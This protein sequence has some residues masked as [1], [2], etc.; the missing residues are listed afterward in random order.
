MVSKISSEQLLTSLLRQRVQKDENNGEKINI[1]YFD[2]FFFQK[3]SLKEIKKLFETLN[4]ALPDEAHLK[5]LGEKMVLEYRV[6]VRITQDPLDVLTKDNDKTWLTLEKEKE[7]DWDL[8]NRYELYLGH[9][10]RGEAVVDRTMESTK[11]IMGL[12]G[13]PSQDKDFFV[14]GMVVG[15]VQAGKTENFNGV[16]NRA[17]DTGYKII[18]VV[19]GLM[20]DLRLQ[21]QNRLEEDVIGFGDISLNSRT[22]SKQVG[23]KGVGN[24]ESLTGNQQILSLTDTE[25]DFKGLRH[26]GINLT[27]PNTP[28]IILVCKKNVSILKNILI[29]L[30][31][32]VDMGDKLSSPILILDDEADNASLNNEGHKGREYASKINGHIRAIL[33]FFRKKSYLGYTATPFANVLQDRNEE[34]ET[35]WTIDYKVRGEAKKIEFDQVDNLFPEDFISLIQTPTNYV[36]AKQIFETIVPPRNIRNEKLP[37]LNIVHDNISQFPQRLYLDEGVQNI[38]SQAE[39]DQK[40][41]EGFGYKHWLTFRD[42]KNDTQAAKKHDN[43]PKELPKSLKD[44]VL[45][46]I[47]AIAVRDGRKNRMQHSANYQPHNT[48]LVHVSLFTNW[49][50]VTA[51]FIR[52]YLEEINRRIGN[53]NPNSLDS[54]YKELEV[55]WEH[56]FSSTVENIREYLPEDYVDDYMVPVTFPEIKPFIPEAANNIDTLAI[57]SVTKEKLEY[58]KAKPQKIIAI[59]GNRLS[60]GFTIEGLTVNYFV[61]K[62]NFS[63][64]LLQMARWFGYR[65]GYLDCC[66]LFTTQDSEDKFDLTTLCFEELELAIKTMG[67]TPGKTPR[68][69]Q[70]VVKN[71]PNVLK[72]TRPSIMRNTRLAPGSF[73]D[74]L[75]M[76]T[77]FNIKKQKMEKVFESFKNNISPIF[78]DASECEGFLKCVVKGSEIVSLL[79]L[80]NNFDPDDLAHFIAYIERSQKDGK[81][82]NWTVAIKKTGNASTE[83]AK[84]ILYKNEAKLPIDI[85]LAKRK[86]PNMHGANNLELRKSFMKDFIF[87]ATGKSANIMSSGSDMGVAL[88]KETKADAEREFRNKKG[89]KITIPEHIYREKIEET[90]GV[91]IIYFFDSYYSFNQEKGIE[92]PDFD[93]FVKDHDY[94]LDI[95]IIGYALGFPPIENERMG[96]YVAGDFDL[97]DDENEEEYDEENS[98]IPSDERDI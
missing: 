48:M 45:C 92:D 11:K 52:K 66:K 46:F 49:Q 29:W 57:N 17:L 94:D 88:S 79:N 7:I 10:G 54:I 39:W 64:T 71:S 13:D 47:L 81:L 9:K 22:G 1:N 90:D 19:S 42:Y 40:T 65:P 26:K 8:T 24:I 56:H 15:E 41:S 16:I 27:L 60:R 97:D 95:P 18:I 25:N 75:K 44:A 78:K 73:Q 96:E 93:K 3:V 37:L 50:N 23:W 38:Q 53:E 43:F 80:D 14:R 51:R 67:E 84:G 35:K 32:M 77:K 20:E 12:L 98:S 34:A 4:A 68:N 21:T 58:P 86:G 62:T 36:G 82:V 30:D 72:I 2:E 31:N 70:L 5:R 61:R 59:G 85:K 76:T 6:N 28:P 63:D 69:F 87:K 74:K 89:D 91:L 83:K 33:A 55:I